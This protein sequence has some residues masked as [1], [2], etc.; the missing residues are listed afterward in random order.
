MDGEKV[1]V[2]YGAQLQLNINEIEWQ[3]SQEDVIRRGWMLRVINCDTSR[4]HFIRDCEANKRQIFLMLSLQVIEGTWKK[5]I[6]LIRSSLIRHF[7]SAALM[8]LRKRSL[9][10]SKS[11]KTLVIIIIKLCR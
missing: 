10:E 4:G 5:R 11:S 9:L 2:A 8:E 1:P 7:K 3:S 6:Q